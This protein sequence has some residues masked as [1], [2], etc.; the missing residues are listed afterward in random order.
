MSTWTE[1]G[2]AR[3]IPSFTAIEEKEAKKQLKAY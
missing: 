1:K 3:E 2:T